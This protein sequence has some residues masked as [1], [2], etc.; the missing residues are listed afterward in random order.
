MFK[1]I[2]VA[3]DALLV[4]AAR[5]LAL[6]SGHIQIL[7]SIDTCPASAYEVASLLKNDPELILLEGNEPELALALGVAIRERSPNIAVIVLG[8][9]LSKRLEIEYGNSGIEALA[10]PYSTEKFVACVR[11]AIY[12][13]RADLMRNLFLFLP[14]KAGNGASTVAMNTAAAFANGLSKRVLIIEADFHSGVLSM[15]LNVQPR[16][17][18]IDVLHNASD[19]DYSAWDSCIVHAHAMDLLLTDR[20]KKLPLPSWINYHQLLRFVSPRYDRVVVDLPEIVN[21]ATA[22]LVHYAKT[23]FVVCTPELSSLTLA[24]QRLKELE[25]KGLPRDRIQIVLNRWHRDDINTSE[26]ESLLNA[27]VAVVI[28]NDYKA[29]HGATTA[30]QPIKPQSKLGQTF[31]KFA[32]MLEEASPARP[33]ARNPGLGLLNALRSA[34]R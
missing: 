4:Q 13:A 31:S 9:A 32:Q 27:K 10:A 6:E 33:L 18:L 25:A 5:T 34:S 8:A 12:R 3:R 26:V 28:Q 15:V 2:V 22:D 7:R 24:G 23:V 30:G 21:D 20:S 29:V 14:A 1:T 19:L 17:P 16:A 11:S